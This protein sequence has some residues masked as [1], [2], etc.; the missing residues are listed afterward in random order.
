MSFASVDDGQASRAPNLKE[1]LIRLDGAPELPD[2]VAEHFSEPSWLQKVSLHVDNEQGA[3]CQIDFK[4]V[5]LGLDA[6]DG[7]VDHCGRV[8]CHVQLL[9]K[10]LAC[11]VY[12]SSRRTRCL[13][14]LRDSM[15]SREVS[16]LRRSRDSSVIVEPDSS[17]TY[18]RIE[19]KDLF[20]IAEIAGAIRWEPFRD[21]V[22]IYR[23]YGDGVSGPTA[24]LL[25]YPAEGIVPL[26]E[27]IGYEHILVLSGSQRDQN[28]TANAGTLTINAPGTRHSVVSEAGCIVL[29]IY[30]KPVKFCPSGSVE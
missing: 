5:G 15:I 20:K 2:V 26:H 28:G 17:P 16:S 4:R 29:A 3:A 1:A 23:L 24:A 14:A 19:L 21:G 22:E 13:A 18:P 8:D 25:R 30:E 7:S 12:V 9:C 10:R 6:Q 27:H 11:Q